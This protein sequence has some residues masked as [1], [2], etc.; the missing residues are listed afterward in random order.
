MTK[1]ILPALFF[2]LL[3]AGGCKVKHKQFV[4]TLAIEDAIVTNGQMD[5]AVLVLQ[6]R[7]AAEQLDY[8]SIVP[9]YKEK[10]ISIQSELLDKDW[11]KTNLLKKGALVF[12]ECYSLGDLVTSLKAADELIA[13]KIDR[14]GDTNVVVNPFFRV[15]N[16]AEPANS[17]AG[18][19]F[20]PNIGNVLKKDLPLFKK[21]FELSK[22]VFPADALP[23]M[24][25]RSLPKNNEKYYE[26][27]FVKD[28]DLKFFV[29]N[30]VQKAAVKFY[31]K[32][33]AVEI[34]LDAYGANVFKRMTTKNVNK[35]IAIVID[36][37]I[38]TAPLVN[39]PIAGGNLS[40]S[41]SYEK[42]E[43]LAIANTLQSGYMPVQLQFKNI[44]ELKQVQ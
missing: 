43:A 40:L 33:P 7:L 23:L 31:D 9:D 6:K 35:T 4:T 8:T 2:F 39:G 28:N 21:Y 5:T 18:M 1:Y 19:Q 13:R 26:V 24:W 22:E 44:E 30:H 16:I 17:T 14:H 29:S 38:L 34:S 42:K 12:Y 15:F 3:C 20:P 36:G 32:R 25:E 37:T 27:Y 41:G 11:I 10:Q